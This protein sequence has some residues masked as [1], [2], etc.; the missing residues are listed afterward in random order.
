MRNSQPIGLDKSEDSNS[1]TDSSSS[2]GTADTSESGNA[3]DT[4]DATGTNDTTDTGATGDTSDSTGADTPTTP[5]IDPVTGLIT[6][7]D[8][9]LRDPNTGGWVDPDDGFIR[10]PNTGFVMGMAYQYVNSMCP[11]MKQ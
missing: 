2:D 9:T 10:D 8:G 4:S 5:T 3:T 6:E 7:P 11:T 1:A